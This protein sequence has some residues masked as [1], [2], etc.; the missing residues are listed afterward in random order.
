MADK[1]GNTIYL[2]ERECSIQRRNQKVIEEAPSPFLDEVTRKKMGN[3]A[4]KLA[5]KV[6]YSSAG[7]VEFIVDKNKNFYF[8]S[9]A[10][11]KLEHKCTNG[12]GI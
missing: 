11:F 2:G 8:F 1:H 9:N 10:I 7:T 4:V 5:K 3:Q 6:G 12:T